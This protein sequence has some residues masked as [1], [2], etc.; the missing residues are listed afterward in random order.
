[1]AVSQDVL[2]AMRETNETFVTRAVEQRQFDALDQVY[3]AEARVLPPGAAMRTG[4]EQAKAFWREA[5]AGLNVKSARLK[6]IE[7]E[8]CGDNVVEIGSADLSLANGS[9]VTVKYVVVWKQEEGV[10]KW[11]VDIWNANS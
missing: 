1:M 5:V 8:A 3:T 10:W 4:R 2:R 11:A 7:A 6:T 9:T